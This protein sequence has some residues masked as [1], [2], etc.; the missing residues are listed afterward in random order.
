MLKNIKS[1]AAVCHRSHQIGGGLGEIRKLRG[2]VLRVLD[3][4]RLEEAQGARQVGAETPPARE[5][6]GEQNADLI[7]A[8]AVDVKGAHEKRRVVDE[9]L[10]DVIVPEG[11]G[12]ST[13]PPHV[14]EVEA[15]VV[16]AVGEAVPEI[17]IQ[18]ISHEAA[19]M[20]VNHIEDD[21]DAIQMA[22][23]HQGAELVGSGGDVGNQQR[24]LALGG[25]QVV[26]RDQVGGQRRGIGGDIRKV[27]REVVRA[28]IAE[29]GRLLAPQ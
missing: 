25:E 5:I 17:E 14:G 21:A 3:H 8:E 18:I 19:G 11:E 16:I 23:V 12:K 26:D 22:K 7:V 15:I 13:G 9:E 1:R 2:P 20:V 27:G 6:Q 28:V 29:G 24:R 4:V 10:A